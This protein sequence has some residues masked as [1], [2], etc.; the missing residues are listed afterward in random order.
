MRH[1]YLEAKKNPKAF[2]AAASL[3]IDE[4]DK[5]CVFFKDEYEKAFGS[6]SLD[7]SKPGYPKELSTIEDN[8][9]FYTILLQE[10]CIAR[11]HGSYIFAQSK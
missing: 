9:F 8:L 6:N 4:F 11:S 3:N 7:D 1:L 5:L 2:L 10:L